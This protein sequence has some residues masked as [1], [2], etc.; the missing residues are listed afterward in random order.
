MRSTRAEDRE[1]EPLLV[2]TITSSQG[3]QGIADE[4]A[5]LVERTASPLPFQLPEWLLTWWETFR[6]NQPFVR[7]SL[8][9]EVARRPSGEL[10]G[11]VPFM[12]T[13]RPSF[14]P[15]RARTLAFLGANQYITEQRAPIIDPTYEAEV[16]RAVVARLQRSDAWDWIAWEGL[17]PASAFA[18]T[19]QGTMGVRWRRTETANVLGLPPS[20]D[21]FKA[22]LKRNIKESLRHCYNSLKR[23]GLTPRLAVAETPEDVDSALDTFFELHA[24]RAG[25]AGGVAHPDRF[26]GPRA[27][28]FLRTVC[29]RLA[30]RRV[31]RIFTLEIDRVPVASRV[32]F[33]MPGSLYLYYS[34]FDPKWSRYSVMTTTVAEAIK[35]AID[36]RLASVHLSMGQDVSKSRWCPVMPTYHEALSVR[37]QLRSRTVMSLYLWGR[38]NGGTGGLSR[39]LPKRRFD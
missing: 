8:R 2:S 29:A 6:Q 27:K 36:R 14:G 37:P 21:E 15:F 28:T 12:L 7:D 26:A 3:L 18:T 9:V 23:E 31:T 35:Y 33:L 1:A 16:A 17:Q 13:E 34:G 11:I 22:G 32:A 24:A 20:W 30:R 19:L 10:V 5:Q 4:W 39:L 38:V 25:Q